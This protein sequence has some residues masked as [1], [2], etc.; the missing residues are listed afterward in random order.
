MRIIAGILGGRV[1]DSP[2]TH[3]THP[4]SEKMRGALFSTLGDLGNLTILDA[5]SG[6]GALGFEA[7][8]RGATRVLL[9]E[10][11]R[12]AQQTIGHNVAA[13]GINS[14]VKLIRASTGSWL[15]TSSEIQFDVV[16]CD[17]PYDN[18]QP[19]LLA[20]LAERVKSGGIVV[21]SLPPDFSVALPAA[22]RQVKAKGYGDAQLVFFTR[23]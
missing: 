1:F 10:S 12:L 16:L 11:D 7:V 17:P 18:V 21:F 9:I 6:S 3:K 22:F 4:M 15:E 23:D 13:L 20:R 19:N 5:F 8:S 14:R 2:G